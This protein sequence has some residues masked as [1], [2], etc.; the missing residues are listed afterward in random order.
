MFRSI[1][2][3]LFPNNNLIQDDFGMPTQAK[4]DEILME[5]KGKQW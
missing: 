2:E 5:M 4:R 3:Q 1:E